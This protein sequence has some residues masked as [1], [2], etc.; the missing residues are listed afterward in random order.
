MNATIEWNEREFSRIIEDW[1]IEVGYT[2][3]TAIKIRGRSLIN[4]VMNLMPPRISS[5]PNSGSGSPSQARTQM[6]EKMR[7]A[8]AKVFLVSPTGFVEHLAQIYGQ[9]PFAIYETNKKGVVE[10]WRIEKIL[11]NKNELKAFHFK[12]TIGSGDRFKYR[13]TWRIFEGKKSKSRRIQAQ[14]MVS[15]DDWEKYLTYTF[16]HVGRM[17]ASMAKCLDD[18]RLATPNQTTYRVPQWVSKH[19]RGARGAID[20]SGLVGNNPS[21][22]ITSWARGVR[23][24]KNTI[25]FAMKVESAAMKRDMQFYIKGVKERHGWT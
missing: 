24:I 5:S 20:T 25:P 17:R 3:R 16:D 1:A 23:M 15:K 14:V 18:P 10:N 13:N 22:T 9:G 4:R 21:L 6:K 8:L 19:V 2:S 11:F 12:Q 7:K